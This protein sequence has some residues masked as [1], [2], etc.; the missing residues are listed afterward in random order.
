MD[1]KWFGI[2]GRIPVLGDFSDDTPLEHFQIQVAQQIETQKRFLRLVMDGAINFG[3]FV[4]VA[5]Y[6]VDAIQ[7]R[8]RSLYESRHEVWSEEAGRWIPET[9][10]YDSPPYDLVVKGE[11][12]SQREFRPALETLAQ[13]HEGRTQ[14]SDLPQN[15][16][17]ALDPRMF[18]RKP[19][20][21]QAWRD[22][23][24]RFLAQALLEPCRHGLRSIREGTDIDNLWREAKGAMAEY[25]IFL[26]RELLTGNALRQFRNL[27]RPAIQQPIG[28]DLQ[29]LFNLLAQPKR[30]A[31]C[32]TAFLNWVGEHCD[33]QGSESAHVSPRDHEDAMRLAP[34]FIAVH[35]LTVSWLTGQAWLSDLLSEE[36]QAQFY[37]LRIERNEDDSEE[38]DAEIV[39]LDDEESKTGRRPHVRWTPDLVATLHDLSNKGYS[40]RN[41]A[42]RMNMTRDQIKSALSSHPPGPKKAG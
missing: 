39:E 17:E 4:S 18:R 34:W 14:G 26:R 1:P 10:G 20:Y 19:A 31:R 2:P 3:N 28:D 33:A 25:G 29:M 30:T 9:L 8:I 24:A 23:L 7:I 21:E 6:P 16:A 12:L 42:R 36:G 11:I 40:Q 27:L 32:L 5:N 41:I 35:H 13:W 37:D 38:D 22:A 15:L